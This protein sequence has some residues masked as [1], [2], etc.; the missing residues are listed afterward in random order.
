M[1]FIYAVIVKCDEVYVGSTTNPQRR[2]N[3]HRARFKKLG[4]V[5]K[6]EFKVL[7]ECQDYYRFEREDF[8]ITEFKKTYKIL[9]QRTANSEQWFNGRPTNGMLGKKH[10]EDA[11]N[12]I[13]K[14]NLGKKGRILTR[15]QSLMMKSF[16]KP[17][18]EANREKTRQLALS[19]SRPVINLDTKQIFKN[20]KEAAEHFQVHRMSIRHACLGKIKTVKGCRFAFHD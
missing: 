20:C 9:N 1:A 17:M 2:S 11:K 10:T 8:W 14:F 16:R 18:S 19:R 5:D 4:I 7:E 15:E 6:F 13:R 3:E 12:K